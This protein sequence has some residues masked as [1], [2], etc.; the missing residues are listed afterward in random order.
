MTIVVCLGL[1]LGVFAE[2]R[3][4][5][6]GYA[7]LSVRYRGV[8]YKAV[9]FERSRLTGVVRLTMRAP[10]DPLAAL[11]GNRA[12]ERVVE[13]TGYEAVGDS[14]DCGCLAVHR[15]HGLCFDR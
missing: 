12:E 5:A 11:L 15:V 10:L 6:E 14:N 1:L 2:E 7:C 13:L 9:K 8:V 3:V 4:P